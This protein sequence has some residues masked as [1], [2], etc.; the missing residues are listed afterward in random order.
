VPPSLTAAPSP[1]SPET[2]RGAFISGT[3]AAAPRAGASVCRGMEGFPAARQEEPELGVWAKGPA[4]SLPGSYNPPAYCR[5][6]DA[7]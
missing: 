3:P 1:A 2:H 4:L 6:T 7:S 5:A